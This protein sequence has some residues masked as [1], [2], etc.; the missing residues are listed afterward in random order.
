MI[1]G[2]RGM[3]MGVLGAWVWT[4][5]GR[6]RNPGPPGASLL[7]CSCHVPLCESARG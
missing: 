7:I 1:A 3:D 2:A 4:R 5:A 6:D